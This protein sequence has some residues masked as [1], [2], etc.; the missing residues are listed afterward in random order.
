LRISKQE[1][2]IGLGAANVI[3]RPVC[4]AF[5]DLSRLTESDESHP[6]IMQR[7]CNQDSCLFHAFGV[8]L[9]RA[10]LPREIPESMAPAGIRRAAVNK[11]R[12][13]KGTG[14]L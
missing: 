6:E 12:F 14:S 5:G 10:C 8:G 7:R 11:W 1:A 13:S 9:V 3:V 2:V 4:H